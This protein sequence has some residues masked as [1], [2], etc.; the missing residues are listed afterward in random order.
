MTL[1]PT[2]SRVAG[3]GVKRS[4]YLCL[5]RF[6]PFLIGEEINYKRARLEASRVNRPFGDEIT[7]SFAIG[8]GLAANGQFHGAIDHYTPLR[9]VRMRCHLADGRD[10]HEYQLMILACDSQ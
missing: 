10:V 4:I 5:L 6:I 7:V 9:A 8:L 1:T 3:E 2:L